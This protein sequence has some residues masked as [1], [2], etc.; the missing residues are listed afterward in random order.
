MSYTYSIN[1]DNNKRGGTAAYNCLLTTHTLN[2]ITNLFVTTF[3]IAHIYSF[4]GNIYNYLLNVAIFNIC[5]Y[6]GYSIFY[7]PFSKIVD[8]T[9]RIITYKI[10]IFIKTLLVISF[11]FFGKE[12][13]NY[14]VI[15]GIM[16]ALADGLYYT[17][18][19][20]LRQE[21]IS[22][23][24]S[25]S[26]ASFF[27]IIAKIVEIICPVTLGALIDIISFSYTS[28]LVFVI[29]IIQIIVSSRVKTLRPTG[30]KFDLKE[31]IQ[32]LKSK[33]DIKKRIGYMYVI[34]CIY[35][36]SYSSTILMNICIML[37]YGTNFSLGI[38]TS[39]ISIGVVIV[40][41]LISKFTKP[42]KRSWLFILSSLLPLLVA[43]VFVFNI[44]KITIIILSAALALTSIIYK[45]LY[46]AHRNS[47]LKESGL[48]DNIAEHHSII[49]IL[50]GLSR[51]FCFLLMIV[52]Y[53]IHSMIA[54]KILMILIVSVC[55]LIHI[56]LLRYEKKY[57]TA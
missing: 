39:L 18:Y 29:C 14:L 26:Y 19:N 49:E 42:G 13:A 10:G 23:K 51:S 7:I 6:V 24:K 22:R 12:L 43:I 36:V 38:I 31:Y 56:L 40:I 50:V 47:T 55:G 30:S 34:A 5:Y 57:L 2:Y 35:G 53:F 21:M 16:N 27:Y 44:N 46:D 45:V 37:E 1:D 32:I 33:P 25:S 9:N 20:V 4:D 41:I 15:A 3:L 52:V 54:F 28:I 11:I 48:Y 8:K 17:S